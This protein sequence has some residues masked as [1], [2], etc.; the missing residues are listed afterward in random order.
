MRGGAAALGPP[1]QPREAAAPVAAPWESRRA[2][3]LIARGEGALV[4]W[5]G[6]DQ[7]GG[8][9]VAVKD[10]KCRGQ[11]GGGRTS[12]GTRSGSS[13]EEDDLGD[14]GGRGRVW[15]GM[16]WKGRAQP[17]IQSRSVDGS[18]EAPSF[19][20]P[21]YLAA[22]EPWWSLFK[23]WELCLRVNLTCI[24]RLRRAFFDTGY[25]RGE[26]VRKQEAVSGF[27]AQTPR[28]KRIGEL[29]QDS[30]PFLSRAFQSPQA[31]ALLA[32]GVHDVSGKAGA[33]LSSGHPWG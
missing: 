3:Y 25:R 19:R 33:V 30:L 4:A 13:C 32:H 24:V 12:W 17:Q 15:Y 14:R 11:G 1:G 22:R 31:L 21:F 2:H 27:R 8:W 26:D 9:G 20:L 10:T 6:W 23:S 7:W 16:Q 18:S 5:W 28:C 29:R